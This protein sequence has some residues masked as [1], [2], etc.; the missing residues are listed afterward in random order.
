MKKLSKIFLYVTLVLAIALCALACDNNP[1]NPTPQPTEYTYTLNKL[2][3]ELNPGQQTQ[4]SVSVSPAKE[5]TVRYAS[6]APEI[7]SVDSTGK[8]TA[9]GIGSANISATVDGNVLTCAVTVTASDSLIEGDLPD[10]VPEPS[11]I[12]GEMPDL[13]V[14]IDGRLDDEI[15]Q[16]RKWYTQYY[17]LSRAAFYFTTVFSEKGLYIGSR[18]E[19]Q[20]VMFNGRNYFYTNTQIAFY[21]S[22][23][24]GRHLFQI[25]ANNL[26]PTMFSIN[27]RSRVDGKFNSAGDSVGLVAEFFMT[28]EELGF[29]SKP[30]DILIFPYYGCKTSY[31]GSLKYLYPTFVK[32]LSNGTDE[33]LKFDKDGYPGGDEEDAIVGSHENGMAKTQG[34]VVSKD[35]DNKEITSTTGLTYSYPQAAFFRKEIATNFMVKATLKV[36]GLCSS[37]GRAG[38][39]IYKNDISYR[40]LAI[41]LTDKVYDEKNNKLNRLIINGYTNYPSNV[42]VTD[43]LGDLAN[44][45]GNTVDLMIYGN[46]G[47]LYYIINGSYLYSEDLNYIGNN[48]LLGFYSFNANVTFS[49]YECVVYDGTTSVKKA[50]SQYAYTVDVNNANAS[51]ASVAIDQ[52]G[53]GVGGKGSIGLSFNVA[54]GYT[55]APDGLYYIDSEGKRTDIYPEVMANGTYAECRLTGINDNIEIFCDSTV[56]TRETVELKLR[57]KNKA[58]GEAFTSYRYTLIGSGAFEKYVIAGMDANGIS[59]VRVPKGFKWKYITEFSGFRVGGGSVAG[60]AVINED[61]T[62]DQTIEV[63]YPVLGGQ[64]TC[65]TDP[66]FTVDSNIS[67]YWDTS[68]EAEGEVVFQTTNNNYS[69]V[70]FS[71]PTISDYHVAY[72]EIIN[73]T[74]PTAFTSMENDPAVGFT[75]QSRGNTGFIGM[76]K[77]NGLRILPHGMSDFGNRIDTAALVDGYDGYKVNTSGGVVQGLPYLGKG[78][79]DRVA[80]NN[81]TDTTSMLMIRNGGKI[82]IYLADKSQN[83]QPNKASLDASDMKLIYEY[84]DNAFAGEAAIGI[85]VTVSYNLRIKYKNCWILS[86]VKAA[87]FANDLISSPLNVSFSGEAENYAEFTGEGLIDVDESGVPAR[88]A[89]GS[90]INVRANTGLPKYKVMKVTLNNQ[91]TKYLAG[92]DSA[93]F[94]VDKQ[95]TTYNLSCSLVA[96]ITVSGSISRAGMSDFSKATGT[97]YEKEAEVGTFKVQKN[98]TFS[99]MIPRG[100]GVTFSVGIDGYST[101]LVSV[102]ASSTNQNMGEIELISLPLGGT[103][104][105]P[106]GTEIKTS[107]GFSYNIDT[108]GKPN[109][110]Y[111]TTSAP[112]NIILALKSEP[113]KDAI[114]KF[115]YSRKSASTSGVSVSDETDLG[116]GLQ[117]HDGSADH[118]LLMLGNGVRL[119]ATGQ[120]VYNQAYNEKGLATIDI[121]ATNVSK[122]DIMYIKKGSTIYLYSKDGTAA[123]YNLVY[124]WK[125]L[126]NGGEVLAAEASFAIYMTSMPGRFM[127]IT[128]SNI[129]VEPLTEENGSIIMT[130]LTT[131]AGQNGSIMVDSNSDGY[132]SSDG[133]VHKVYIRK[134]V[135]LTIKPNE[136]YLISSLVIDGQNV[137]MTG[138]TGGE[139]KIAVSAKSATLVSAEFV[140]AA[141]VKL[142]SG[143]VKDQYGKALSGYT[144]INSAGF[145][146]TTDRSGA[147]A[148]MYADN[149]QEV[150]FIASTYED[151]AALNS[152]VK[153]ENGKFNVVVHRMSVGG[154]TGLGNVTVYSGTSIWEAGTTSGQN[155]GY[156]FEVD[157]FGNETATC[158]DTTPTRRSLMFTG[159]KGDK[160]VARASIKWTQLQDVW[161]VAGFVFRNGEGKHNGI[162]V[163]GENSNGTGDVRTW[164]NWANAASKEPMGFQYVGSLGGSGVNS[165]SLAVA[166]GKVDM[167]V[168]YNNGFVDFYVRFPETQLYNNWIWLYSGKIFGTGGLTGGEAAIG[169]T[170]TSEG[171]KQPHFTW[172]DFSAASG[173]DAIDAFYAKEI[174]CANKSGFTYKLEN[175]KIDNTLVITPDNGKMITSVKLGGKA[176]RGTVDANGVYTLAMQRDLDTHTYDLA[177]T[178]A[179]KA[180]NTTVGGTITF[181]GKPVSGAVVKAALHDSV[182][183]ATA[184]TDAS[185]KYSMSIPAGSYTLIVTYNKALNREKAVTV[186]AGATLPDINL[187]A[188]VTFRRDSLTGNVVAVGDMT[189]DVAA[190]DQLS[191]LVINQKMQALQ[192]C[193]DMPLSAKS[194]LQFSFKVNEGHSYKGDTYVELDEYLKWHLA[195]AGGAND[196]EFGFNS[197]GGAT[198]KATNVTNVFGN[199]K[200]D[201]K[202]KIYKQYDVRIVR[203]GQNVSVWAKLGTDTEWKEHSRFTV[204]SATA[205]YYLRMLNDGIRSYAYVSRTFFNFSYTEG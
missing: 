52:I 132:L 25:D 87:A 67:I 20:F 149:N 162:G 22:T 191:T 133:N 2:T 173:Q 159:V 166:T 28:W 142:I 123:D 50:V 53:V 9:L 112:S 181:M 193:S 116:L 188:G 43:K 138:Y 148:N 36:N 203:D 58:T 56:D 182:I 45:E 48:I 161:P 168:V 83:V 59:V 157:E 120:T 152:T 27:A 129:S 125:A 79:V 82:F 90:A 97:V 12:F 124:I 202:N 109:A 179:N 71:G 85:G 121:A 114:V 128:F 137:E 41:E 107:D 155:H 89:V 156:V 186:T 117:I 81:R 23:P 37:I 198:G 62:A 144:M 3:A 177:V 174:N 111:Y 146:V 127:N 17:E 98:G 72:I 38:L 35:E 34:W 1:N 154:S 24:T 47:K 122:Y 54:H 115:S 19:D 18:S 65:P 74:D 16:N 119:F 143:T 26:K 46:N 205:D 169:L 130:T 147:F 6:D 39:L 70:Y 86:G 55:V 178:V 4:L 183:M 94:I 131:N 80:Y 40:S 189:Y 106:G 153:A 66:G 108:N 185:G 73:E 165:V 49:D 93:S 63:E 7:A 30:D 175:D 31:N 176:V 184:Q 163:Y 102:G 134:D 84:D 180:A 42:T 75:I 140:N 158:V 69:Y 99:F 170:E 8:V 105:T 92:G 167:A 104:R 88:V 164:D 196:V 204:A 200:S 78:T 199:M 21:V 11:V 190:E 29:G 44:E 10:Y 113:M 135:N 32:V 136:G 60:E 68:N 57:F 110:T 76:R 150:T 126:D 96:G 15:W 187:I 91:I 171:G 194:T 103:I 192:I 139:Y 61:M 197:T 13:D 151:L 141:S 95:N 100:K 201:Y 160:L 77:G 51:L 145:S 33:Y 195:E 64:A 118:R 101:K 14:I 172:S 5:I